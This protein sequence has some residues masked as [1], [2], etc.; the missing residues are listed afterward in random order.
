MEGPSTTDMSA[1]M[2]SG[3]WSGLPLGDGAGMASMLAAED[4]DADHGPHARREHVDPVD[5]RL[6]P[7]VPPAGDL[8]ERVQLLHELGLRLLPE[9]HPLR[10]GAVELGAESLRDRRRR[11]LLAAEL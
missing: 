5:D 11:H 2:E 6:G 9:E 8:E 4:L 1:T 3:I 10:E 7:Y